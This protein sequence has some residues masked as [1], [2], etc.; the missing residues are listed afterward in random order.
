MNKKVNLRS[1]E[2]GQN[3]EHQTSNNS[4]TDLMKFTYL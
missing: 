1:K 2:L 3:Y 4:K